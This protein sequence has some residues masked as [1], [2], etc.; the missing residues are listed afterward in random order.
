M[1]EEQPPIYYFTNI[2]F[3]SSFYDTEA[4]T[5]TQA[6]ALYLR[7]TTPD[8]ATALE[9]FNVGILSSSLDSLT[10]TSDLNIAAT[11]TTGDIN[12]ANGAARGGSAIVNI[13]SGTNNSS[14]VNIM[15]G[16][17]T[18]GTFSLRTGSGFGA[19]NIGTGANTGSI[20]IGSN[21]NVTNLNSS[22]VNLTR[23]QSGT[24]PT[25]IE[26]VTTT[27]TNQLDFHCNN[28]TSID[29]DARI[30]ALGGGASA[31]GGTLEIVALNTN[32]SL[33]TAGAV[34]IMNNSASTGTVNIATGAGGSAKVNIGS[35]STTG[36]IYIG[37]P[38]NAVNINSSALE[39]GTAT[40]ALSVNTPIRINYAPSALTLSSQIGYV[41]VATLLAANTPIPTGTTALGS[42]SLTAGTWI[43]NFYVGTNV[44]SALTVNDN[45]GQRMSIGL[46]SG[47]LSADLALVGSE[48]V[49]I[50]AATNVPT[51]GSVAILQPTAT[52]VYYL[53][54]TA[55]F[56]VGALQMSTVT[57]MNA[58]R[59]G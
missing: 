28:L 27:T 4:F 57:H 55:S 22:T 35:G 10:P 5:E 40:K 53:N 18:N 25:F 23:N 47:V 50:T 9:T 37:N 56:T 41:K 8:T 33:T 44:M 59:I 14:S 13:S 11:Q 15:T 19:I 12:I 3:N 52:T 32:I 34:N 48:G 58:V 1:S 2:D 54:Y 29:Y 43:V 36:A 21:N 49:A 26:C 31:G 30:I 51:L 38:T 24:N 6:N 17:N 46:T 42:I 7:K 20:T 45:L 39:L 16:T